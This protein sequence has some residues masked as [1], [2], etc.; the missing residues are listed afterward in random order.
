MKVGGELL[1]ALVLRHS[2]SMDVERKRGE[3]FGRRDVRRLK[4]RLLP[5]LIRERH[6]SHD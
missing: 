1:F 6:Q 2:R 4:A 3:I 5:R